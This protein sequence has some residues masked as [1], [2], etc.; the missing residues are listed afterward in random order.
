MMSDLITELEREHKT[1]L[2]TLQN[3]RTL[4]ITSKEGKT[5][6]LSAKNAFLAHLKK[7]DERLYPPMIKA[8]ESN[9]GLRN[10]LDTFASNMDEISSNALDF[11]N[12]YS[13]ENAS[14]LEFARDFGSLFATLGSRIRKEELKLHKEFDKLHS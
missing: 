5:M 14:G 12:K 2:E 7:E 10:M 13:I 3:V 1:L 4:G 9:I 6:F 11:F 8:S